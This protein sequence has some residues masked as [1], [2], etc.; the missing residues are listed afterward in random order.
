MFLKLENRDE[1]PKF[2]RLDKSKLII[3]SLVGHCHIVVNDDV[4]SKKHLSL[5]EESEGWFALD[6]GSTNGSY[7]GDE[8]IVPGFRY[9]INIGH[10]VRL[11]DKIFISLL[12]KIDPDVKLSLAEEVQESVVAKPEIKY[13]AQDNTR[14]ITAEDLKAAK[15]ITEKKK[16]R[17]LQ[18]QKKIDQRRKLE[19]SNKMGKIFLIAVGLVVIGVALNK[20]WIQKNKRIKKD[21]II[22]KLKTKSKAGEEI[23]GDI[24]GFRINRAYLLKRDQIVSKVNMEKCKLDEVKSLCL[25]SFIPINLFN[26]IVFQE[27]ETYLIYLDEKSL[28][29][30]LKSTLDLAPLLKRDELLKIS[31]LMFVKESILDI[32]STPDSSRFYIAFYNQEENKAT[33]ISNVAAFTTSS[34]TPL[35]GDI[36]E[37]PLDVIELTK[38]M[39]EKTSKYYTFY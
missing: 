4:I 30:Y 15:V 31:V 32:T 25:N 18:K 26:G 7:L 1:N 23:E 24:E 16:Q 34:S 29:S 17:E 27:P 38:E 35:A 33:S 2:Y 21:T 6:M 9:K 19:E 20:V 28:L 5:V 37:L 3:G 13:E 12:D 36:G 8:Q 11:G 22:N 10:I 39:L 14:V